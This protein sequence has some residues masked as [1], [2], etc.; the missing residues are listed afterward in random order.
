[1]SQKTAYAPSSVGAVMAIAQLTLTRFLRSKVIF[2]AGILAM[3]PLIPLLVATNQDTEIAENWRGLIGVSA[4]VQLLVASLLTAPVIAEEIDDKTYAY[5]WSR[6]IPRWS[7]LAGKLLVGSL[8][9][10]VMI[11]ISLGLGSKIANVSDVATIAKAVGGM[12][13]GVIA[14]GCIASA[15][16]TLLPKHPLAVSVSYFLVLDFGIGVMPFAAARMSVMHNVIAIS[17]VGP[18]ANTIVT[19][20][21]W[22]VGLSVFWTTI[23]LRRLVR[24]ELSTGS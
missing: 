14:T 23:T 18:D 4:L 22:L 1:M 5:L 17:G 7:I 3:L 24:K 2:V 13:L 12:A 20:I 8:V 16:G 10:I 9:A 19:S 6:P 15:L 21:L 11:G